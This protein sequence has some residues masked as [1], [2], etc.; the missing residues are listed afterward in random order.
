MSKRSKDHVLRR[1]QDAEPEVRDPGSSIQDL[2]SNILILLSA[3]VCLLLAGCTGTAARVALDQDVVLD[4][5]LS[6]ADLRTA[7]Q[8][9]ARS[10]VAFK[11]I[12][13]LT[14]PAV[15]GFVSMENRTTEDDFDSY[16]LLSKI[17]QLI[18]QFSDAKLRFADR[19]LI[20]RA[21][22][23][24]HWTELG[25]TESQQLG[26]LLG[27]DYFLTGRA[28][29]LANRSGGE[30]EVYYRL[31]FRLVDAQTSDIVWED[32]YEMKKYGKYEIINR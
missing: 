10:L 17:R 27:I 2:G 9:M 29:S 4:T 21:M 1:G 16:N 11:G 7:S 31:S 14:R 3:L 15:I 8:K 19:E 20:A 26:T 24:N 30:R 12:A 25:K 28:Y 32:D 22:K 13:S 18:L 5:D 6:S 23:D